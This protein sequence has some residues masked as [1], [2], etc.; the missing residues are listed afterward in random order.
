[1]A[2]KE[3]IGEVISNKMQKTIVVSVMYR[4]KH[5]RYKRVIRKYKKFKVHDEKNIAN[6]GDIVR[7]R[8][9]RPI[10]KEKYFRLVEIIKKARE[11]IDDLRLKERESERDDTFKNNT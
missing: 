3:R 9:T 7:I 2:K 4:V 6:I 10:S 8:E 1:M 5:P 11:G